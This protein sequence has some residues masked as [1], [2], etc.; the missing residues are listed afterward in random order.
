MVSAAEALIPDV[1]FASSVTLSGNK[2]VVQTTGEDN[3][4]SI[5]N[6][7]WNGRDTKVSSSGAIVLG[8]RTPGTHLASLYMGSRIAVYS[9]IDGDDIVEYLEDDGDGSAAEAGTPDNILPS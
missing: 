3:P 2:T 5:F 9:Q 8:N 7:T 4:V 1:Y 6:V